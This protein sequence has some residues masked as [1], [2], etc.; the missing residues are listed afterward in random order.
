MIKNNKLKL[1]KNWLK[2]DIYFYQFLIYL[3]LNKMK[4]GR[5]IHYWLMHLDAGTQPLDALRY[6]TPELFGMRPNKLIHY[7]LVHLDAGILSLQ[8]LRYTTPALFENYNTS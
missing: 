3:S 8:A 6:T 1:D 2:I 5:L 4:P 7:W